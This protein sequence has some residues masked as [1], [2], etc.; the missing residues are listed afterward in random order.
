VVRLYILARSKHSA[1]AMRILKSAN[2][3]FKAIDVEKERLLAWIDQT[4]GITKLPAVLDEEGDIIVEGVRAIREKYS[5][6]D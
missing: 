2:V 3:P 4:H 1:E 5:C 6:T